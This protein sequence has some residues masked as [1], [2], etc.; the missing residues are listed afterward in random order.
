MTYD[1]TL[2]VSEQTEK[3]CIWPNSDHLSESCFPSF[4]GSASDHNISD[5]KIND[6]S[7]IIA[8]LKYFNFEGWDGADAQPIENS[9]IS[10]VE[11]FLTD[12]LCLFQA[13]PE[14]LPAIDGSICMEWI[15]NSG[16]QE[17]KIFVDVGPGT[18]IMS[19]I[20]LSDRSIIE[21]HFDTYNKDSKTYL[22]QL[23]EKIS[24][25]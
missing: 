21:K 11:D 1:S 16:T 23:F 13:L 19:L 20:E 9:S 22:L 4:D 24:I 8:D 14:A 18:K 15:W 6:L 3:W 12:I 7:R 25:K 10:I 2:A 5:Q 17:E